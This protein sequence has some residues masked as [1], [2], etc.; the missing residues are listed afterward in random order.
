MTGD[1]IE[2]VASADGQQLYFIGGKQSAFANLLGEFKTDTARD[3]VD[4]GEMVSVTYTAQ[5]K[6][7][8]DTEP[9]GYYHIFG[10]EKGTAPRAYYDTL[11]KRTFLVGGSYH[12]KEAERG[13]IN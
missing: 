12:L 13:I 2:L 6:Q 11:N 5:K 8:G 4:L 1:E 7:A 3:K 9:K 10:E